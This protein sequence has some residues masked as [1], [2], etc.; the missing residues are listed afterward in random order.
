MSA[1]DRP[2]RSG[3]SAHGTGMWRADVLAALTACAIF[4][5]ECVAYAGAAGVPPQHALYAAP[6]SLV[7]YALLGSSRRVVVGATAAVAV[8][9]G[10][11]V[12]ALSSD[13]ATIVQLSAALAVLTG[14]ILL[15]IGAAGAGF[16]GDFLEPAALVGFLA[17]L[18]LVVGVGQ[19]AHL[20]GVDA[21][22]GEPPRRAWR[23]AAELPDAS[24]AGAAV[25]LTALALLILMDY[26]LPRVPGVLLVLVLGTAA[27]SAGHF[28]RHGIAVV[29]D[30]PA[31][32]PALRPPDVGWDAWVSLGGGAA[33][34]ALIVY[35]VGFSLAVRLDE[36]PASAGPQPGREMAALG[37]ANIG[38]GLVGGFGVT[39]NPAV[40]AAAAKAVPR[41][42]LMPMFA[43]G[44]VLVVGA[45]LT[46][47]LASLPQPV[48]AAIVLFAVRGFLAP[49]AFPRDRRDLAVAATSL[50]GVVTI[51]LLP[52]LLLSAALS[53][54]LFLG[55]A[56]RLRVAR[57]GRLPGTHAY[58]DVVRHPAA[59]EVAGLL[60]VRPNGALFY[61]N[62]RHTVAAIK[63]AAR[64]P[65]QVVV[66]D[67]GANFH[68]DQPSLDALD[69]L[70]T[71]LGR[72]GVRLWLAHVHHGTADAV[73][74]SRLADAPAWLDVDTAVRAF[75]ASGPQ[76]GTRRP[77]G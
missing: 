19:T 68:I 56:T 18:A 43:A 33:G 73:A 65:A 77:D 3:A 50:V 72:S 57:L 17:G 31:A 36:D 54:L 11:T 55:E 52:G 51:G 76:A 34:M 30:V 66:L 5:P 60:I 15:V 10:A 61:G 70:R 37:L 1:R 6:V 12:S 59:E 21:G 53:L 16:V 23:V 38:A 74:R 47:L 27:S 24:V 42:R 63:A 69:R 71:D 26:F 2:V 58:V 67:L 29:G 14:M 32:Y 41:T 48:L 7:V 49:S 13:P 64:G 40:S 20:L 46:P 44:I 22:G 9:S 25:G 62:A 75:R 4:V 35:A 45:S 8:F 39:A 28:A